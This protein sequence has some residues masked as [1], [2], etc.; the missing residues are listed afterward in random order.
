MNT[1]AFNDF[2][3]TRMDFFTWVRENTGTSQIPMLSW[4]QRAYQRK[5]L[6]SLSDR[7][8]A[9]IG[10]TR[11]QAILEAGKPFWKA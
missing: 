9:D 1:Y 10:L 3:A 8:L 7:M 6:A 5:Q 2:S 11:E 4:R